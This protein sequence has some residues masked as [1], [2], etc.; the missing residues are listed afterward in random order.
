MIKINVVAVGKV[1][2]KYFAEGIAEYSKRLSRFCEFSLIEVEEE[3][4]KK[5][6]DS[7]IAIIKKKEGER[8]LPYLKGYVFVTAPEGKKLSSEAFAEKIK[9]LSSR[10][11]GVITFVIGGSYGLWQDIKNRADERI[12]FSDMT[13]PH[14]LFR[15]LLTEQLYRA[16]SLIAGSAYHK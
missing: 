6:D 7:V 12:S 1:K 10:G 11:V 9:A 16:F 15:L 14:T 2:E 4:F 5:T 3:N 8:L 13:F